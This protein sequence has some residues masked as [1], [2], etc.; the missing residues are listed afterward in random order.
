MPECSSSPEPV[1]DRRT[2]PVSRARWAPTHSV[3]ARWASSVSTA[4]HPPHG[5]G[6]VERP[7][8]YAAGAGLVAPGHVDSDH[9][10]A[11]FRRVRAD[12]HAVRVE[13]SRPGLAAPQQAGL[14][15]GRGGGRA[16]SD[17]RCPRGSCARCA[18]NGELPLGSSV[19]RVRL[20]PTVAA[21]LPRSASAATSARLDRCDR[22]ESTRR[23]TR[24]RPCWVRVYSYIEWV[25][26]ERSASCR[27]RNQRAYALI[28]ATQRKPFRLC[29]QI[30][31]PTW[32]TMYPCAVVTSGETKCP[33]DPAVTAPAASGWRRDELTR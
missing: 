1:S 33:R 19:R 31:T 3:P 6:A 23:R 28:I 9:A 4:A 32:G 7:A 30:D 12:R 21:R 18:E 24:R 11:V 26:A 14:R 16:C 17:R 5:F 22:A 27:S 2:G 20:R 29:Y 25:A 8:D 15:G 10:R 13:S